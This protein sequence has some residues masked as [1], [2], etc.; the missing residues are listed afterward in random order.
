[1]LNEY[2]LDDSELDDNK[3]PEELVN[4]DKLFEDDIDDE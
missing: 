2:P 1:M 3:E 4:D